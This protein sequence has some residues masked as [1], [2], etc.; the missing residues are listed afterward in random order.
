MEKELAKI[1]HSFKIETLSKL[2]IEGNFFN[3]TRIS[4]KKNPYS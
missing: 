4:T 2:G 1:R 3:L